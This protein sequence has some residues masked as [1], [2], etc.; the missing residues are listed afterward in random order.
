MLGLKLNHVSKRGPRW[1]TNP[2]WAEFIM[3]KCIKIFAFQFYIFQ[4]KIYNDIW[5]A[6]G[7]NSVDNLYLGR[8]KY[9]ERIWSVTNL[10][11]TE[12]TRKLGGMW[13][14]Q[15]L[16]EEGGMKGGMRDISGMKGG[17]KDSNHMVHQKGHNTDYF[18][19]SSLLLLTTV[20]YNDILY[21]STFSSAVRCQSISQIWY[22]YAISSITSW[23]LTILTLKSS[24]AD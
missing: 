3:K 14:T 7:D 11:M 16:A 12:A 15:C 13:L 17:M 6:N 4:R 5:V 19:T 21:L 20:A 10:L 1:D 18:V 23:N 9:D 2:Y 24:F 22:V 8:Q